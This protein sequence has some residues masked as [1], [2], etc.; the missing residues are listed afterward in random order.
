M[1][2]IAFA[3]AALFAVVVAL[4]LKRKHRR[5][6]QSSNA[7]AFPAGNDNEGRDALESRLAE[8]ADNFAAAA[9]TLSPDHDALR[10]ALEALSAQCAALAARQNN[11]GDLDRVARSAIIRLLLSLYSVV[12]RVTAL[13]RYGEAAGVEPA[14]ESARSLIVKSTEA[15]SGIAERAD[16][17]AL[18]HLEA[19]LDVLRERLDDQT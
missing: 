18:V 11:G 14:L 3:F 9:A 2:T 7:P 16:E 6:G 19:E 15:F 17:A 5:V 8:A 4:F 10:A 1:R 12:E 13:S